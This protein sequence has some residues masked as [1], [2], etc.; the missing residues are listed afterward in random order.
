MAET[1][2]G[3]RT[4]I[5]NLWGDVKEKIGDIIIKNEAVREILKFVKEQLEKLN[6]VLKKNRE[7]VGKWLKSFIIDVVG[8]I[9][10]VID[11]FA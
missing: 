5:A 2:R 6:E 11:V 7:S 4:Q 10:G 9:K 1:F 3:K 8:K